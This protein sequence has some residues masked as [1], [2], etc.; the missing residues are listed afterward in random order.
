MVK[1]EDRTVTL[2]VPRARMAA[3]AASLLASYPV[4]DL[5]VEEVAIDDIVRRLF[6]HT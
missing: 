4:A 3:S 5:N 1:Y 6:S 2:E